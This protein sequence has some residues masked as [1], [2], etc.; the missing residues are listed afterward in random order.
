M[1]I[2]GVNALPI[3]HH[4]A[5]ACL[6]KDGN[7][8]SFVEEERFTEVRHAYDTM[9]HNAIQYCLDTEGITIDDIDLIANGWDCI[10][11]MKDRGVEYSSE[12]FIKQ[13]I[14][15][16]KFNYIKTP[17]VIFVSH[18]LAHAAASYYTSGFDKSSI[19]I[20]DGQGE[21]ESITLAKGVNGK[22]NILDQYPINYSLG[23]FFDA[24]SHFVGLGI[25][26]AGKLMGLAPYGEAKYT[27]PQLDFNGDELNTF[28]KDH[29]EQTRK[30]YLKVISQWVEELKNIYGEPNI[31]TS[32]HLKL[33]NLSIYTTSFKDIYKNIA[34]SAQAHIEKLV[35][36]LVEILVNKTGHQKLV[37][38]GGV[39]LSCVT[40]AKILKKSDVED[41]YIFPAANDGGVSVGAALQ[42]YYQGYGE[43][44][45]KRLTNIYTGPGYNNK[46]IEEMLQFSKINYEYTSEP[47]ETAAEML[48]DG[49]IIGWFQGHMEAGPRALGNRSIIANPAISN[50]L[51][52]VNENVKFRE[53]WRPFAPSIMDEHK[54]KILEDNVDSPYMLLA[55]NVKKEWRDRI[56]SIVHVDGSTRPQTVKKEANL[57]YWKLIN[58]FYKKT[59]VP[60]VLN[61]SFNIK[62]QPIVCTPMQAIKTFYSSGLDV[63]IL[64][65]YLITK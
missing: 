34:A 52:E 49:K 30:Y 43:Y 1:Y 35:L 20:L 8:L 26:D 64:Q 32:E 54:N 3:D 18:H 15:K 13:L 58:S 45:A 37:L 27:F 39:A 25:G 62:G 53:L 2:L 50:M 23:Y 6:I 31:S 28:I 60:L 41:I 38:G 51:N 19:L 21:R 61:T 56:P 29:K 17:E 16:S 42:A 7:I 55:S 10:T 40:N 47:W 11:F 14:P 63:L 33:H 5:S 59:G 12:L 44:E 65:N 24:I 48:N 9:P 36:K 22:I 4:D 57:T 46:E